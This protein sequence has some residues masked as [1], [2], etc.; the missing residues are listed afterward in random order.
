[1]EMAIVM[2][3]LLLLLFGII[4]FGRLLNAQ[5][6]VTEAAREGARAVSLGADPKPRIDAAVNGMT[7][8]NPII[9]SCPGGN[10]K[11]DAVVTVQHDFVFIT[12][13][14]DIA[15]MFGGVLPTKITVTGKGV[16]PCMQ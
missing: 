6:E 9:Q 8:R 2:P 5:I 11:S 7:I 14:S 15:G 4:D 12:P 16:M 3:V 1:V 10:T 13:L